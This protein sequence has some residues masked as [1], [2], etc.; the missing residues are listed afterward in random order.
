M[1]ITVGELLKLSGS[2]VLNADGIKGVS[3]SGVSIDSR[4]CRKSEVFFAIK[5]ERFDGHSFIKDVFGRGVKVV[6]AEKKWL[7]KLSGK[8][9]RSF[10]NRSIVLVDDSIKS[11]GELARNYRRKFLIPVVAVA[12]S[13]GKTSTKDFIAHV[14]SAQYSVLKTEANFNNA[15][16]TPLTLFRLN[17]KHEICVMEVG[18]NHFGEVKNLCNIV[19]PQFGLIT[20]IGKEHLEFLKDIRGVIKE[21]SELIEYLSENFGTYFLNIDDKHLVKKAAHEEMSAFTFG[22]AGTPDVRGRILRYKGFYP[23]IEIKCAK[24]KINTVLNTI[25]SQSYNSAL[26]AAAVGFYFDVPAAKIK[27]ALRNFKP[28][29]GKRN[30]LKR[31]GGVWIIDDTY[32]SNPDSV[33]VALEN[34]KAFKTEGKK[35]IVLADMLELGKQSA[36]EHKEAGILVKRMGFE[37]LYTYGRESFNTFKAAKGIKNNFFFDDKESISEMLK[38]TVKKNDIVLVKGSRSMKMED[39]VS[40]ISGAYKI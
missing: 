20:N 7:K 29:T 35:H 2:K 15:I 36:K 38:H 24:K 21:E 8:E 12:G 37:N 34:L 11:L 26:C 3:F 14:L 6:V 13:N 5:G 17:E 22:S 16:G 18:T 23:E 28:D 31:A 9:K 1:K 32:N 40:G 10:K 39:V 19:E 4:K 27:S 30:Q 33:R 25:G